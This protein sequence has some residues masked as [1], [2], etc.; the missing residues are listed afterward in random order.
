MFFVTQILF[1][2]KENLEIKLRT[3]LCFL[4][5]DVMYFLYIEDVERLYNTLSRFDIH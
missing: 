4:G 2:S 5:C 3:R 1:C